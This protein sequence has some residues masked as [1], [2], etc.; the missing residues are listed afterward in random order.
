MQV[1]QERYYSPEEYLALEEADIKSETLIAR[2]LTAE[3]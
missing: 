3:K 2:L 1:T